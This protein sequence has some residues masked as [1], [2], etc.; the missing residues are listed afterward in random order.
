[1]HRSRDSIVCIATSYG[2]D[3]WGVGVRVLVHVVQ[4]GSGVHLTSPM[5]MGAL[6]SGVNRPGREAD[7]SPPASD[8]V[9]KMWI[10]RST[11]PYTFMA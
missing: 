7:Q 3:E 6:S 9:K 11:P 8:E 5:S 2:L 4:T 1:L 10:Y